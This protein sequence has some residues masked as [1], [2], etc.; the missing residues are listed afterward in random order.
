MKM[1]WKYLTNVYIISIIDHPDPADSKS[2]THT[3]SAT[4]IPYPVC[5]ELRY[6]RCISHSKYIN[7]IH[8]YTFCGVGWLGVEYRSDYV[9][10]ASRRMTRG[11]NVIST[12]DTQF[13]S[14]FAACT[15]V[16]KI[17]H[18]HVC[19]IQYEYMI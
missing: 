6:T 12:S 1:S 7:N 10:S 5:K 16:L 4:L 17:P 3:H 8:L 9:T 18:D 15:H 11:P 13:D 19:I 14:A 2:H